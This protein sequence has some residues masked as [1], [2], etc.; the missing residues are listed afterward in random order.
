MKLYEKLENK[1]T[2]TYILGFII[3]LGIVA[4][5]I[6]PYDSNDFSFQPLQT[7]SRQHLL[8][9]NYMGQDIFSG[10]LI[11]F[12][13]SVGIALSSALISTLFGTF[14]AVVCAYYEGIVEAVIIKITE[15]FLI[16]PEIIMIMIFAAF[17]R[18]GVS[19]I[20]FVI[21]FFSWSRVTR[22]IRFKAKIAMRYDAIQ[23]ALLLK[24]GIFHIFIK[25]W[26]HIYP[27]VATMFI[28]Q[29]SKAIMYEAN[30]A[31]L[32]IGDPTIKSW[33]RIIRQAIDYEE[34][35]L[36]HRYVWWL[37][38]P[39]FCIVTFILLLSMLSFNVE[40]KYL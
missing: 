6:T 16:L 28:I 39:A 2:I 36:Q 40:D 37:L 11:G 9:T 13:V 25:L 32:G 18:P 10:L 12:R 4:P 27:S 3:I 33:G 14:L 20:I 22:I 21:S 38:P 8:G 5:Y 19:N 15:L 29:C 7:P 24:G 1:K 30:L 31:F 17:T 23:Y 26:K 35:F 34:I